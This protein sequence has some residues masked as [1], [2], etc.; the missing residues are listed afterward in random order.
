MARVMCGLRYRLAHN[1]GRTD[2][3]VQASVVDHLN[4]GAYTASFFTNKMR[5]G[6]GELYFGGRIR[7]VSHLVFQPLDVKMVALAGRRPAGKKK[8]GETLRRLGQN[9][10]GVAHG[11]GAKP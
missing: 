4:D 11:R 2:G 5:P 1:G 9:Q 10:E 3:T 7:A 6:I 8:T